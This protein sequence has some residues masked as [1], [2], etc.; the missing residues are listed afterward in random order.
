MA[1]VSMPEAALDEDDRPA[2]WQDE[3]RPTRQPGVVKTVAE[4]TGVK[5]AADDHFRS[6]VLAPDA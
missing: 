2:A 6:S 1:V 4:A 5:A 3:I